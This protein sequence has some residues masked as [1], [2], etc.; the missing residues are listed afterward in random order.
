MLLDDGGV[1][2]NYRIYAL[3]L[4]IVLAGV[5]LLAGCTQ[6]AQ[7][8]GTIKIGVVASLTGPVSNL[9]NG[10][11]DSAQVAANEINAAGGVYVKEYGRKVN[12]T[13]IPGDDQSTP[14]GGQTA[15]TK[16][17]TE[18][19]VDALVGGYSSAVTYAHEQIVAQ[20]KVPYVVTGASSPT[21]THRTDIDTSYIFH[22][23]PTTDTYGRY[24]T[25]FIDQVIRPAVDAKFNF[26]ASRPLRLGIIYQDSQFGQGVYKAVNA[27]IQAENLNTQIVGAQSFKMAES[28][29]HT[30]L[31]AI[32][33]AKPDA[34]YVAAFTNEMVPMVTQAQRDVGLNT[35]FL[36]VEN[37]DAP[38]YYKGLGGYANYSI[39][40]SRF[41]P[42]TV[43][44][45]SIADAVAAFKGPYTAE[46]GSPPDMM[47]ASTYEGVKIL[48][49]AISNAGTVDKASVQQALVNLKMPQMIEAMQDGTI[50]FSPDFH[51]SQF[52]LYM[53]QLTWDPAAGEA[54][55]K[56]VWPDNLKATD[57]VLPDWYTPGS[58]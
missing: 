25:E 41:S 55:P 13:L 58:A 10:M 31:T 1:S 49:Q 35:I 33:A 30:T 2:L 20:Y 14:A 22:H 19:K 24:T 40:E 3:I 27:T 4:A 7:Q 43:P 54:R 29:F 39:I 51:E 52:K 53:E 26:A 57:F 16:L 44:T 28:D 34:I 8:A 5:V 37:N 18:N 38:A 21:I 12:I 46:F 9:G 32:K 17:I 47:G 50:S 15:V 45:G 42:Y 23:C 11:Y 56:I 6:T 48:A 36:A